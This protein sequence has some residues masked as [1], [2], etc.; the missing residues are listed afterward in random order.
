MFEPGEWYAKLKKPSWNPPN[1]LF[2]VVWTFLYIAMS[3][4]AARV[5]THEGS[6]MALAF[7]A[8]QIAFNTLWTP[9]FFGLRRMRAAFFIMLWLWVG[10][11]GCLVTFWQIDLIAGLL[12]VPYLI[13]VTV[14]GALNFTVWRLNK[15]MDSA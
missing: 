3:V 5:A 4:A 14:A 2:P 8:M 13:W 7:F 10:V 15:D 11:A 12:F 9:I 1:W 6:A